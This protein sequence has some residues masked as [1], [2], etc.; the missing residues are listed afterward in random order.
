MF[1]VYMLECGDGSYYTGYTKDIEN[2][3]KQHKNG[4]GGKYTRS[5]QP[6]KI[7]YLETLHSRSAAMS[8]EKQI[9]T[10]SRQQKEKM[11]S[12]QGK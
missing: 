2:R 9:K 1:Y 3:L 11:V 10:L 8:R 4:C 12:R 7:V 5:R 6:V